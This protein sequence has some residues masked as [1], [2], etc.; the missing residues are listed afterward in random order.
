MIKKFRLK[1]ISSLLVAGSAIF[2]SILHIA[3]STKNAFAA[4]PTAICQGIANDENN[5]I[6][7][8]TAQLNPVPIYRTLLKYDVNLGTEPNETN[9]VQSTG[10]GIKLNGVPLSDI[11]NSRVD[12]ANGTKYI[13]IKIPQS[14]QSSLTGTIMLEVVE[15]TRFEDKILDGSKFLL[16]NGKWNRANETTFDSIVWNDKGYDFYASMNGVLLKFGSNLSKNQSEIDGG[17]RS[18]NFASSTGNYIYLDGRKLSTLPGAFVSYHS[19]QLLFIYVDDMPSYRSLEI[20]SGAPI[21]DSLLPQVNLYY[22]SA[23]KWSTEPKT[24]DEVTFTGIQWNDIGY[25][26]YKDMKGVLLAYNKNLSKRQNEIDAGIESINYASS[27]GEHILLGGKKLST[28]PGAFVSY[29]SQHLLFIYADNMPSYRTLQIEAGTKFLDSSL[30]ELTLYYGT[31]TKWSTTKEPNAPVTFSNIHCNN[32]GYD[33][34]TGKKGL[35]LSYSDN[36]SNAINEINGSIKLVNHSDTQIGD[37]IKLD[38]ISFRNITDSEI[39]YY[40]SSY[41]WLYVPNMTSYHDLTI[42][43]CDFLTVNLPNTHLMLFEEEWA[44]VFKVTNIVNGLEAVDYCRKDRKTTIGQGYYSSLFA[45]KDLEVRLLNFTIGGVTYQQDETFELNADT[46]IAAT[47]VGFETTK[48]ASIRMSEPSAMRFE[49]KIEKASYDYLVET[50]SAGNIETGTYIFK[51]DNL[52]LTSFDQYINDSSKTDG[53]DYIKVV[54]NGFINGTSASLEAYYKYYATIDEIMIEDVATEYC[55]IG[56]MKI[57]DGGETY[58]LYGGSRTEIC[59]RSVYDVIKRAYSDYKVDSY[60]NAALTDYLDGILSINSS[61]RGMIIDDMIEGYHS[62]YVLRYDFAND[63]YVVYGHNKIKVILINGERMLDGNNIVGIDGAPYK[64]VDCDLKTSND[65]SIFKFKLIPIIKASTLVDFTVQI[66]EDRELR[67]LQLTDTQ[68]IDSSQMRNPDRLGTGAISLYSRPNIDK[69]CFNHIAAL[70]EKECP[71]LI[72]ITGDIVYGEFDDSGEIWTKI[73]EFMDSF[74]IPWAP[75]FGNHDNES[76]KGVEWQ[77]AQLESAKNCLFKKGNLTGNGNYSIGLVDSTGKIK[78][79]IYML[80]SNGCL[81]GAG[82]ATDQIN[83]MKNVSS[84]IDNAYNEK[85]PAFACY[86]IPSLDFKTAF[87]SEYGFA[88][89]EKFNLDTNG[90]SGD[91]GCKNENVSLF[92]VSLAPELKSVNVDGVFAGHDHVNNYSI[93]HDGIRYTYG[94]KTGLYDYY[95]SSILGGTLIRTLADGS[96]DVS[97]TYL[98]END[99]A[100]RESISTKVTIMSDLHF[101][102]RDYGGFYCTKSEQKFNKI[103]SETKDSKFYI[104]LGD[105]VNSCDGT[106]NNYYHAINTMKKNKLNVYNAN[107]SGY[108]AGNRMMYNLLG[109]HEVAYAEKS[110]FQDYAPYVE[111]VGSAAVFKY[112]DMMFVAVDAIFDRNGSDNP[113]DIITCT[114]FTIPD[115]EIS[116]LQNEINKNMDVTTKGIVWISHVALQDIDNASQNKLLNILKGYGLP[117]TVFEGHTHIE[118]YREL[119]DNETGNAYCQVYTLPAVVL[120]NKYPYYN[121]VFKDGKVWGIDKHTNGEL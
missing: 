60:E 26:F 51:K 34:Y 7:E 28:L 111:G 27:V 74:N 81:R 10:Q 119:V 115:R 70:I 110:V 84:S 54:N 78:R 4:S 87:E 91:F 80:D 92:N 112:K 38:G 117:M 109:N 8:T 59:S 2:G 67:I 17:I 113:S 105:T 65:L 25:N 79:T 44:E 43:S 6:A 22:S 15:G 64:M 24:Y 101:D 20:K 96:F 58:T 85:V 49:N 57:T 108:V 23:S 89:D 16:S 97:H 114:E 40:G 69:N 12:Y 73:I 21:L 36:L 33:V 86:H 83:W 62:P 46:T 18:T 47:V 14:Y 72:I 88:A 41:L 71:D 95:N 56:Y 77:C 31:T 35:M 19:Q 5:N 82:I 103:M 104:N 118:A 121:V 52:G 120:Y 68:I 66:P 53:V 1:L 30:P 98:N 107:G 75:I 37:K 50:Y 99:L 45:N 76:Y 116:Y 42:E 9:V 61:S 13:R 3:G 106:L 55:G 63:E 90:H 11:P 94:T 48:G 93:V 100:Q 102:T 32:S 29:H 39:M